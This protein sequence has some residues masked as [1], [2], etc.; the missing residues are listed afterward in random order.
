MIGPNANSAREG[1]IEKFRALAARLNLSGL[2]NDTKW[3][4]LLAAMRSEAVWA[5]YFRYRCID[6]DFVSAW[7][8][9]WWHHVPMPMIS[10]AWLELRHSE[11]NSRLPP[12]RVDHTQE[13]CA[14]LDQIGFDYSIG[15]HAI[16]IYGYSPHDTTEIPL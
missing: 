6:S 5:P 10:V 14:I 11:Y 9:E 3:N 16:R 12:Q 7:D 8:L 1:E 15:E 13:L 4:E 2:A